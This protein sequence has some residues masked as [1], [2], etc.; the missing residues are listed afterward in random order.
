MGV[1][2]KF[3]ENL[4]E[5]LGKK[6]IEESAESVGELLEKLAEKSESLREE[7]FVNDEGKELKNYVGLLVNGRGIESLEGLDTELEDGDTVSIIRPIAGG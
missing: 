4:R 1:K 3:Y 5:I 2:V 7:L 6:E